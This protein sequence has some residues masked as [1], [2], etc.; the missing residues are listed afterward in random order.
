M[1]KGM[2]MIGFIYEH[3]SQDKGQRWKTSEAPIMEEQIV[4][5]AKLAEITKLSCWITFIKDRKLFRA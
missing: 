2:W 3:S 1:R 5:I 4:K